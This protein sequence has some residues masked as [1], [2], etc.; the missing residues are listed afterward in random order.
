MLDWTQRTRDPNHGETRRWVLRELI[1]RREIRTDCDL[2]DVVIERTRG[3]RVLD[4][5][6]VAH[7]MDYVARD[8]WRHAQVA[9][10]AAY[11]LG[12]DVLADELFKL[13]QC[14]YNV[15][16]T[17]ATSDVDLGERFE[18]VFIG[19]VMEHVDNPVRLLAFAR[20]HLG[21]DGIVLALTPNPFSRKFLRRIAR[22]GAMVVNLDHVAWITPSMALEIGR[23]AGL[24]LTHYHLAKRLPPTPLARVIRRAG[25][26]LRPVESAYPDF[27]YEFA[28]A[29]PG[30]SLQVGLSADK[31][32]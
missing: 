13:R 8:D 31:V 12:I 22:E 17:D 11:C 24:E 1:A 6:A 23:R 15:R 18:T 26:L 10:H 2:M 5:G 25:R 3:K 29:V 28:H 27:L 7:T 32:G 16:E 21:P 30:N 19:D 14:G 20:R 4:I 9:R